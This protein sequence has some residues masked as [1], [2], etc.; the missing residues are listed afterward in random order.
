MLV[1]Q[2]TKKTV[3]KVIILLLPH[4]LNDGKYEIW[5]RGVLN[6]VFCIV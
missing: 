1:Q 4:A 3:S 6:A 5:A 2:I